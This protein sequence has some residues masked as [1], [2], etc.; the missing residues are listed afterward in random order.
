M[1]IAFLANPESPNGW[2]RGI[3]PMVALARRGHEVRQVVKVDG[4]FRA[5][6][7]AGCDVVHIHR[8]HDERALEVVR[9]A[10]ENGI[11]VVWDNDD[12]MTAVPKTNVAYKNFGGLQGER[13]LVALGRIL[14]T[15]DLVT[16]PSTVLAERFRE[17]GAERV[18]VIEN[19]VRDEALC[20]RRRADDGEVIVGWLAGLEHHLDVER[21]PIRDALQ[22]LLDTHEHVRVV[23][24]GVGLG[25]R[26]ERYTHVPH[27]DFVDLV[28]EMVRFDIGIAPIA[29]IAFNRG[30]S[31]V[32][33]KEYAALGTPWLASPIGPYASL[34]EKLGGRLVPDDGWFEALDRLVVKSRER[35]KLAKRARKW[36]R[37]QAI[38]ANVTLWERALSAAVAR[39]S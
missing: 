25:L 7:V 8:G 5:D 10:K 9:H 33:L 12:D 20:A 16:T 27:L 1:R 14:E 35:A 30:R 22:R 31:N 15:A 39:A 13:V 37:E 19:Y 2:Y 26:S 18:Q 6:L 21:L 24:I 3:G 38:S 23:V 29:D 28:D 11:A 4:T 36:G 32:K 34:G 17:L